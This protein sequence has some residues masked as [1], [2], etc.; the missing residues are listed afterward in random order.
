MQI[1]EQCIKV[2]RPGETPGSRI[3]IPRAITLLR[4]QNELQSLSREG[5]GPISALLI[6]LTL[7]DLRQ[8]RKVIRS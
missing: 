1:A 8:W 4:M 6:D 2:T 5:G 7:R 3:S